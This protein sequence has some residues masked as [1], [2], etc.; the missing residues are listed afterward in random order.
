M[1]SAWPPRQ[2]T[3]H[4]ALVRDDTVR[5]AGDGSLPSFVQDLEDDDAPDPT[6]YATTVVGH[7]V[8]LAPVVTLPQEDAEGRPDRLHVLAL[9]GGAAPGAD[10]RPVDDLAE[11]WRAPVRNRPRA[12]RR[13]RPSATT[14]L[15]PPEWHD[16]VEAWVDA[17]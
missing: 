10:W 11:Q 3:H 6:A 4:V 2:R 14:G 1:I 5:V 12:V 8:H 9:R 15:V 16:R 7:G 17:G 13:L